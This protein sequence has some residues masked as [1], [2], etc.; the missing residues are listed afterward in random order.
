VDTGGGGFP[1]VPAFVDATAIGNAITGNGV[2]T[3]QTSN[4]GIVA[5]GSITVDAPISAAGGGTLNLIANGDITVRNP[6]TAKAS[7]ALN[8]GL[9]AGSNGTP[10]TIATAG[11]QSGNVT[12]NIVD[13]GGGTFTVVTGT[14]GVYTV[15]GGVQTFGGNVSVNAGSIFDSGNVF[16]S[17]GKMSLTTSG[18]NISMTNISASELTVQTGGGNFETQNGFT[19]SKIAKLNASS[20]GAGSFKLVND[21]ALSVDGVINAAGG[22]TLSAAGP[23]T[24]NAGLNAGTNNVSLTTSG[25]GTSAISQTAGVITANSLGV[26]TAG[27]GADLTQANQITKLNTTSLGNGA[28]NLKN[29]AALEVSGAVTAA[30]GIT[31]QTAGDLA[32][33]NTL[34]SG[35]SGITLTHSAGNITESDAGGLQGTSLNVTTAAGGNVTLTANSG[36]NNT[37]SALGTIDTSGGT[38]KYSGN[39]A[40]ATMASGKITAG[41]IDVINEKQIVFS[42][43]LNATTGNISLEPVMNFGSLAAA[44]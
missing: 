42:G 16:A 11:K 1:P 41:S 7:N 29:A 24:L 10:A 5:L 38:F 22:I 15:G 20:L 40:T 14:N 26:T 18:G 19:L 27:A 32:I 44:S 9:Y 6:I 17:T 35:A 39:A 33:N 13:T 30:G 21:A 25:G 36:K 23:L 2:V 3:V 34:N 4:V 37:L 28:L 12:S 43:N 8:L 31:L